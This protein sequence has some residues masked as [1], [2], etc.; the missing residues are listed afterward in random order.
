[1]S[2]KMSVFTFVIV[3]ALLMSASGVIAQEQGPQSPQS[4]LGTAFTY[5]GQLKNASGPINGN[6]DFQFSLWDAVSGGISLASDLSRTNVAV[7]NG[8]FTTP[9]DFG[10]N[11]FD[12]NA[13]WLEI[14]V[15]CP[16]GNGSYVTLT[17]R[18]PLT[19]AP[20]ALYSTSTSA[21]QG[22]SITTTAPTS[23]QVLKWNG[24]AWSPADDEIGAPGSGDISAVNVGDGLTGGGASGSVTLTVAFGG[25]GSA[26]TV[27]RSD[28]DH[29]GVYALVAHAHSG[30]DITSGTIGPNYF[31]AYA[32]LSAEGYLGNAANDL[33]LNNGTLQAGL[34]AD[35]L[36]GYHATS[37][38]LAA[39]NHWGESWSGSGT[40]L[41]LSGGTTGISGTGT[42]YGVYGYSGTNI[43]VYGSGSYLGVQGFGT[44]TGVRGDGNYGVVGSGSVFGVVGGGSGSDSTGVYA[45][46]TTYG[47][48]G[49]GTGTSSSGVYG[50]GSSGVSG[51]GTTYGISGTGGSTGVRGKG[52]YMGVYGF[53]D[54]PDPECVANYGV[55]GE[56]Q[57]Y[58]V[59]GRPTLSTGYGIYGVAYNG[60]NTNYAGYFVGNV[61][62][63]GILSKSGGSFKIDHPLDPANKYLQHSFVES[64]DMLNVY[65]GNI[66]TDANGDATVVL[67]DYFE[68][69]NRDF[70]YQ[71]TVIGQ[72]AQAIVQDEIMG[73]RFTIKTDKP[74]VK[75]SWQVTGIRQDAWAN[76]NRIPVE[77]DKP[78][79][80][81]GTYLYPQGFGQPETKGLNYT[82]IPPLEGK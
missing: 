5:Q 23:G 19:P 49:Y 63:N 8:L 10:V 30:A 7:N 52:S 31:S 40:G 81:R 11:A 54:C 46:G 42:T 14:S 34:N 64:P 13:R 6:C 58:G 59:S 47:V 4:A 77:T 3:L 18:Q 41:T 15:K 38:A 70:R 20:Y 53:A 32:D 76:A 66:T 65:N 22:R 1:M 57:T 36:D 60:A 26:S 9:I 21:L 79:N 75:V 78:A 33:A 61:H 12:G 45:Y 73:N 37:F 17:P 55:Y 68:A 69:L 72:F 80:E 51:I 25:N 24:G 82:P 39:H 35:R 50:N 67:P 71:L 43:G 28:H 48:Q 2:R 16:A 56:A 62:I 29:S 44:G 27:S 74:N